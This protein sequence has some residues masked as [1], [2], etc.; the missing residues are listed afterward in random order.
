MVKSIHTFTSNQIHKEYIIDLTLGRITTDSGWL[1][2][3]KTEEEFLKVTGER[4]MTKLISE[5][6]TGSVASFVI[7]MTNIEQVY[8][9]TYD[10]LQDVFARAGKKINKYNSHNLIPIYN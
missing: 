1:L 10:K 9:R 5:A 3:S 4:E 2:E 8:D 7:Q 6:E